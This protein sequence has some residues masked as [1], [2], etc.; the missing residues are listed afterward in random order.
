MALLKKEDYII[1]GM[2]FLLVILILI[3]ICSTSIN[4]LLGI[5]IEQASKET[6]FK[7]TYF[8]IY[9]KSNESCNRLI[10]VQPFKWHIWAINGQ[11]YLLNESNQT[12][13]INYTPAV[14]VPSNKSDDTTNQVFKEV[15]VNMVFNNIVNS[16]T[17]NRPVEVPYEIENLQAQ[18]GKFTILDALNFLFTKY[19]TMDP[20]DAKNP[21][22]AVIKNNMILDGH[23]KYLNRHLFPSTDYIHTTIPHYKKQAL[24]HVLRK[25]KQLGRTD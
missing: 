2:S 14:L 21:D 25:S 22:N 4:K 9:E 5:P 15:C 19:I 11:V 16:Y 6:Q 13:P 23:L 20:P 24:E 10:V 18:E 8:E 3:I 1:A 12:C 17:A 7:P